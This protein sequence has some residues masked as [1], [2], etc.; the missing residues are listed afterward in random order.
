[1]QLKSIR[2]AINMMLKIK[3][4]NLTIQSQFPILYVTIKKL[5]LIISSLKQKNEMKCSFEYNF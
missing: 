5:T 1:M 2:F 4:N 3:F